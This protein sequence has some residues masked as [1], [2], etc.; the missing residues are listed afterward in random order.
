[1]SVD[2]IL[3]GFIYLAVV[4][5]LLAVGKWVYDWLHRRFVLRTE[6]IEKDNL[7]SVWFIYTII[8]G[9]NLIGSASL[10]FPK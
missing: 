3:T 10:T 9:Y 1:M 8:Y 5:A 7:A 2:R 4:L 6:L